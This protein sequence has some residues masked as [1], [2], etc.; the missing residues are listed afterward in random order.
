MAE[1]EPKKSRAAALA[2]KGGD[3]VQGVD[4]TRYARPELAESIGSILSV[5]E[6]VLRFFRVLIL[7]GL[8]SVLLMTLAFWGEH[9]LTIGLVFLYS[10]VGSI[11]IGGLLVSTF[12]T[13]FLVPTLFRIMLAI[14]S[15]L[16]RAI[17]RSA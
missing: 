16:A 7:T 6:T 1:N 14:R 15:G 17:F 2:R 10:V 3:L 13:L 8:L 12:V 5:S 9:W 4:F 11:L